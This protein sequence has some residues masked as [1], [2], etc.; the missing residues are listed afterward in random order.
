MSTKSQKPPAMP[1]ASPVSVGVAA[2]RARV[3]VIKQHVEGPKPIRVQLFLG[4]DAWRCSVDHAAGNA[5]DVTGDS[6]E[7]AL[8]AAEAA[9][10]A[11]AQASLSRI[12]AAASAFQK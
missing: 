1:E 8:D 9:M 12:H 4:D 6:P 10:L 11:I 2:L 3:D 5:V 7:S